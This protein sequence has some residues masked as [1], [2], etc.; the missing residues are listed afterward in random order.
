MHHGQAHFFLSGTIMQDALYATKEGNFHISWTAHTRTG[1]KWSFALLLSTAFVQRSFIKACWLRNCYWRTL[2]Y[3]H[4]SSELLEYV[5]ITPTVTD[6]LDATP[7]YA[8]LSL[9]PLNCSKPVDQGFDDRWPTDAE[10]ICV[11]EAWV[12]KHGDGPIWADP[13]PRARAFDPPDVAITAC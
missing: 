9:E 7:P 10:L 2:I 8:Q 3:V 1:T 6:H 4:R 5:E 11:L 12:A 13:C